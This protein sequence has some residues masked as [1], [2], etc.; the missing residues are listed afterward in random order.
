MQVVAIASKHQSDAI[1]LRVSKVE[2]FYFYLT[3]FHFDQ[4]ARQRDWD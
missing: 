2:Q 4:H 3:T 1:I